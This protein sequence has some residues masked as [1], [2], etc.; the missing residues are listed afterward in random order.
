MKKS[1]FPLLTVALS[2]LPVYAYAVEKP[3]SFASLVALVI[4]IINSLLVF[5]MA[6]TF[7]AVLWGVIKHWIIGG[8]NEDGVAKGN[9]YLTAGIIALVLMSVIWSILYILKNSFF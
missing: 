8:G 3:K 5:I 9:K 6:L 7:L 4:D 1:I 2:F